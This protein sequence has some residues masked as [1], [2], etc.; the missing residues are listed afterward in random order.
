MLQ[1]LHLHHRRL[2]R[3]NEPVSRG[4]ILIL[5]LAVVGAGLT[6]HTGGRALGRA[7]IGKA[8]AAELVMLRLVRGQIGLFLGQVGR[9]ILMVDSLVQVS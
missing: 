5:H 7:H 2:V 6:H 9:V 1:L 4:P 8:T 3:R